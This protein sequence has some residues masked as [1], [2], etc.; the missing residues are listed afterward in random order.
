MM[1]NDWRDNYDWVGPFSEGLAQV[2]SNRKY[3]FVNEEGEVV[4]PLMYD[5]AGPFSDG[6]A[7]VRLGDQWGFINNNGNV[8]VPLMYDYVD[9]FHDGLAK[10]LLID[11]WGCVDTTGRE[12]LPC[13]YPREDNLP[14]TNNI[15]ATS[16]RFIKMCKS[17]KNELRVLRPGFHWEAWYEQV[18]ERN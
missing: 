4:I 8:V 1:A 14:E 6:L 17:F 2:K 13:I 11:Q 12:V 7:K 10:V 16:R 5:S 3:G 18:E 9:D 15:P